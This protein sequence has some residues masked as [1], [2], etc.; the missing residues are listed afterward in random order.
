MQ[1]WLQG[2]NGA[3][4]IAGL[5]LGPTYFWGRS[6]EGAKAAIRAHSTDLQAARVSR[7]QAGEQPASDLQPKQVK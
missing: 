6:E 2:T 5:I 1:T 3:S 7:Q 4:S